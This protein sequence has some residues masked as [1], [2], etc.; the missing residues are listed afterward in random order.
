LPHPLRKNFF[1]K[2]IFPFLAFIRGQILY[3]LINRNQETKLTTRTKLSHLKAYIL[4]KF[5]TYDEKKVDIFIVG[6]QKCGTTALH[7]YIVQHPL[8]VPSSLK[9]SHYFD[10]KRHFENSNSRNDYSNYRAMFPRS[11][12]DNQIMIDSTPSYAWQNDFL[13]RISSYNSNPK[14]IYILRNPIDR[15]YSHYNMQYDLK[16]TLKSFEG[17]LKDEE[18]WNHQN[19]GFSRNL[20]YINRGFYSEHI[21]N[22]WN[23]FNKEN[24][25]ILISDDLRSNTNQTIERVFNFLEIDPI[26]VSKNVETNK[27]KYVA[28]MKKETRNKLIKVFQDEIKNLEEMLELDL[29]HWL[30]P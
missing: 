25:L 12:D 27:R 28:P 4:S 11:L 26:I 10:Y 30:K 24:V 2:A 19:E 18:N 22:I 8:I 17:A 6:G 14:I 15:A 29:S 1:I 20:S 9:E 5:L 7:N 3:P 21:K 13:K 23:L 16:G